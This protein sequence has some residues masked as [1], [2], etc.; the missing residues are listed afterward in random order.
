MTRTIAGLAGAIVA[1][2]ALLDAQTTSAPRN[3]S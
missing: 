3:E 2:T 1:A